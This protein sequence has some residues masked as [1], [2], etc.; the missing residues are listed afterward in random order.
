MKLKMIVV[1][2]ELSSAT[3]KRL[4]RCGIPAAVLLGGGALA[5][6]GWSP[7]PQ[8]NFPMNGPLTASDLNAN[9]AALADAGSALDQRVTTLETGRFVGTIGGQPYSV[10][11]TGYKL[12]TSTGGPQGDGTYD[13]MQVGGYDGAKAKCAA[14]T[15]SSSAH[16]CTG[17]ELSRSA[18]S[19]MGPPA[20]FGWYAGWYR[21]DNSAQA[22]TYYDCAG[23]SSN[24]PTS[25]GPVAGTG[26]A[27]T[28]RSCNSAYAILC[29]D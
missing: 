6:A 13:G 27:P 2:F 8:P 20:N 28:T 1:D 3:K 7:L 18:A 10:G 26:W 17:D 19:G 16:M 23:Y 14:A 24:V 15:G 9:F 21:Y 25:G 22:V 12:Q 4:I 29:C 11:A 5:Y